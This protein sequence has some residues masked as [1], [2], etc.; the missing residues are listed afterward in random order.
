METGMAFF[1]GLL[2]G[3]FIKESIIEI[4]IKSR[5]QKTGGYVPAAECIQE[6]GRPIPPHSGSGF[7]KPATMTAAERAD[8]YIRIAS[9]IDW[10][11]KESGISS[12]AKLLGKAEAIIDAAGEQIQ[13]TDTKHKTINI[14]VNNTEDIAKALKEATTRLSIKDIKMGVPKETTPPP[15]P[16][17]K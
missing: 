11:T 9:L 5:E 17:G 8:G 16:P 10:L 6:Y 3:W 2:A 13:P 15:P 7:P 12:K 1:I 14:A 4:R